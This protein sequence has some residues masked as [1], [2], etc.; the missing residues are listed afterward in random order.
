M[1]QAVKKGAT[2]K[3]RSVS[4]IKSSLGLGGKK[5]SNVVSNADKPMD[6]IIMPKAFQEV[7]KLPGIPQGYITACMGHSNVGKSTLINHALAAA[8]RQGLLPVMFDTENAF[9]FEY[10]KAMGFK[11]EPQYDDVEVEVV[12]EE[13]GEV[14]IEKQK[15]IVNWEGDFI[16][17]NNQ[18]LLQFCGTMDYKSGKEGTKRRGT[19]VIEDIAYTMTRLLRM[20][21]DGEIEQGILFVWDSVG[22]ISSYKSYDS[23]V[24]NNMW[25]ANAISVAFNSIVND[26]IPSSRKVSSKYTNTFLYI[27]KVWMDSMSNP[28]AQPTMRPKGGQSLYYGARLEIVL[29]GLNGPGIK[30]L[31]ATSKGLNYSYGIETKIQVKKNHLNPPYNVT[32]EGKM[33]ACDVGF[34]ST[35]D[36]EDYKKKHISKILKELNSQV[37]DGKYITESDV[38]FE[39]TEE[40]DS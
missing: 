10:A 9:S 4:D 13:T 14:T 25:D 8:Q 22:S 39:E 35:N 7:T 18:A 38:V 40:E 21:E 37:T 11:A 6:W 1:K 27:N 19:A 31:K 29:G 26:K 24:N 28:M 23:S 16:Y 32:Y 15:Q 12:D 36:L 17:F 33:I 5:A 2:I 3:K 20:Q 34:I 30:R